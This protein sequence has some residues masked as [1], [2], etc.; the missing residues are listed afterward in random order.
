M[1]LHCLLTLDR[2]HRL[3]TYIIHGYTHIIHLVILLNM[4]V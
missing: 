2:I 1:S 3:Y 4:N